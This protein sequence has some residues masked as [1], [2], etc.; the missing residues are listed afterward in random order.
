MDRIAIRVKID[1][2]TGDRRVRGLS[3]F[4]GPRRVV[5]LTDQFPPGGQQSCED[6][7][8]ITGRTRHRWLASTLR[9]PGEKWVTD[10]A[11]RGS[12]GPGANLSELSR[13][14]DEVD[15]VGW[16][17]AVA[18]TEVTVTESEVQ[19]CSGD[20]YE[21]CLPERSRSRPGYQ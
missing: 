7:S 8:K 5:R 18:A 9:S 16:R 20:D 15:H 1:G 3:Q 13:G 19:R 21:V 10:S 2:I 6:Q 14:I 11:A 17:G 4:L 12:E